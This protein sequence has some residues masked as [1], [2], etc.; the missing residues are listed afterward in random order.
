MVNTRSGDDNATRIPELV[1]SMMTLSQSVSSTNS[2]DV[3]KE[4]ALSSASSSCGAPSDLR[5]SSFLRVCDLPL[6]SGLKSS[7]LSLPDGLTADDAQ[8]EWL[9]LDACIGS[10]PTMAPHGLTVLEHLT[11]VGLERIANSSIWKPYDSDTKSMLKKKNSPGYKVQPSEGLA[12]D[13][14]VM[15]WTGSLPHKGYGHEVPAA[16]SQGIVGMSPTELME[17][18]MD[19]TRVREYNKNSTGRSDLQVL[20]NNIHKTGVT[21]VCKST[22]QPPLVRVVLEFVSLI[23]CRKLQLSD[24]FG[25]G[26]VIV[27]RAVDKKEERDAKGGGGFFGPSVVR[28]EI[29]LNVHVVTSL[30]GYDNKCELTNINHLTS[31]M[32]PSFIAKK[33]GLTAT[34]MFVNDIRALCK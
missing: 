8:G 15:I 25:E 24:G 17:L 31:P 14:S 18:L 28:S 9:G 6:P 2:D 32:V 20:Q 13:T 1:E 34:T 10:S 30:P 16:K 12:S 23:H 29:F 11:S 21:K 19:S 4:C 22:A 5:S 26:Y 33:A 7:I 3:R 27:S